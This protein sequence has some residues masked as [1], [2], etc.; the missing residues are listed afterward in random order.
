MQDVMRGTNN[1]AGMPWLLAMR[2]LAGTGKSTLGRAL[3]RELGWPLIDKDD[4]KDILDGRA[5]DA[6]ALAHDIMFNVARR[7]LSLGL[8]AICDST[9]AYAVGYQHARAVAAGCGARLAVLECRCPDDAEW[10]RRIDGRKTLGLPSHHQA[11]WAAFRA[12]REHWLSHLGYTIDDPHLVVNTVRPL[13]ELVAE[14]KAWLRIGPVVQ[15]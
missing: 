12:M 3:S 13:P 9:L 7:Q 4:C 14:V 10:Q 2:G 6:G 11:D 1:A 8:S 15:G 5:L